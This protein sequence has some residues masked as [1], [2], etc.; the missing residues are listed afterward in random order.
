MAVWSSD[1]TPDLT[2]SAGAADVDGWSYEWSPHS[3]GG[4][5]DVIKLSGDA[6]GMTSEPLADGYWYFYLKYHDQTNGWSSNAQLGMFYIDTTPPSPG[7]LISD[8]EHPPGNTPSTDNTIGISWSA[9]SDPYPIGPGSSSGAAGR[10]FQWDASGSPIVPDTVVDD[11]PGLGGTGSEPLPDGTWYFYMRAVDNAGNWSAASRIGPFVIAA[12]PTVQIT[13]GPAQ[14]STNNPSSV[15]FE[16]SSRD[17]TATFQCRLDSA[18]FTACTSPK[19]VSGMSNGWHQF[20]VRG[21]NALGNPGSPDYRGFWV[22]PPPP[23]D[24][25]WSAPVTIVPAGSLGATSPFAPSVAYGPDGSLHV[26]YIVQ[27]GD[28]RGLYY[29]TNTSGTWQTTKIANASNLGDEWTSIAV[30]GAGH[31]HVAYQNIAGGVFY[32]TNL[33]GTWTSKRLAGGTGFVVYPEIAVDTHNRAHVVYF[34][35][36]KSAGLRYATNSSGKWVTKRITKSAFDVRADIALDAAN[37][38]HILYGRDH[39][40]YRYLTN[41]S[42][43]WRGGAVLAANILIRPPA[44]DIDSQGRPNAAYLISNGSNYGLFGTW[45]AVKASS[46]WVATQL[47]TTAAL[48]VD[49]RASSAGSAKVVAFSGAL[50]YSNESGAWHGSNAAP[51]ANGNVKIAF[52]V[53]PSGQMA[54]VYTRTDFSLGLVVSPDP[55]A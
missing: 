49:I 48:R 52:D 38:V 16:F 55:G 20:D 4:A 51:D 6:T 14:D 40:G 17:P 39:K 30:D 26:A 8:Y 45:T 5:P 42:G 19:T 44:I 29:A 18:Q 28:Q 36:G 50:Y 3:V 10:S 24:P 2:W 37:K 32:L 35:P 23:A 12:G 46:G 21:V 11:G 15:Q 22:G 1:N 54:I 47:E 31:A 13:A 27:Y 9:A 7:S 53:G 25:V 41:K 43:A 34:V 33:S